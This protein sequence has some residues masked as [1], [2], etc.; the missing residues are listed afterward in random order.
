MRSMWS[1]RRLRVVLGVS[2]AAVA[3]AAAGCGDDEEGTAASGDTTAPLRFAV[4]DLQGL[5]QL[6]TEFGQFRDELIKALGRDVEF[7]PVADRTAA[8]GALSADQVDL[9]FTGPA[10]YVVLREVAKVQPVIAVS[11][12]N[13]A[14]CIYT[15][16]DS[17]V[18]TLADLKGKKVSMTDIGSTSG[19]LGPSQVLVDA[20]LD[21]REDLEV[22][23]VGDAVYEA[24]RRGDVDAAG[25]RCTNFEDRKAE[26]P[27]L[28]LIQR[29]ADLPADIIVAAEGVPAETVTEVQ[30]AF[31]ENWDA[32]LTA[33]LAGEDN[34]K[35]EDAALST[36]TDADYDV[37]R[38]MYRAIGV[39]D[40]SGFVGD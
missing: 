24:L 36:P 39:D 40:F 25:E 9:V 21:P 22:L 35:F 5:E 20:G 12:K 15:R 34:Q 11:R 32:L 30:E 14:A 13:Y 3:L 37:V 1:G 28:R 31:T 23:T 6:Q 18:R 26:D 16:G 38:D 2:L 29:G 19:H 8:A 27:D 7:F 10:E 4:T 17:P 33:M